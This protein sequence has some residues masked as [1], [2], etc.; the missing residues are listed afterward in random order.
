MICLRLA[1]VNPI[2]RLI[3]RVNPDPRLIAKAVLLYLVVALAFLAGPDNAAQAQQ[4]TNPAKD[5]P[6]GYTDTPFLPGG[7]WRV[8]DINRPRPRVVTPGTASTHDHPGR[9]PS[10]AI[11]LFNG[12]DLSNWQAQGRGADRGKAVVPEWKVENGYIETVPKTGSIFTKEKLGDMQLHIEWAAPNNIRAASQGRGN[13]GVLIMGLYEIQVLDSY[14]NVSYAD[15]QA[16]AIYG[17]YPPLVNASRKPGEWQ[18]YDIIFEAPR[19]KGGLL[20]KPAFATV[21]HNG[22]LVHHRQEL[23]GPMRHKI[24]TKYEP[25]DAE[26]PLLLQSH[27][28]PVRYRNI[29]ARRLDKVSR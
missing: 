28:N 5:Y 6:A 14:N 23:M 20:V 17:Q 1:R 9:P 13:S 12:K 29:W 27:G 22:V 11:V 19:F 15:G 16:A 7:K 18:T 26:G 24:V 8:H 3:A 2:P 10:D 25:H 21:F 4:A